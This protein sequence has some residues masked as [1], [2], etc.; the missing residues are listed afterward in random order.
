VV[1]STGLRTSGRPRWESPPGGAFEGLRG[2]WNLVHVG[3]GSALAERFTPWSASAG[4]SK[5]ARRSATKDFG[6]G[7][8]PVGL[9]GLFVLRS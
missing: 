3:E 4:V 8:A 9:S 2:S 1:A 6:G 7:R 5:T